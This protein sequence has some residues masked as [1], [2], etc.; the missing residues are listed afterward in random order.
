MEG[1]RWEENTC[2]TDTAQ[3]AHTLL[4]SQEELGLST[5]E[6]G[7]GSSVLSMVTKCVTTTKRKLHH[8]PHHPA[9]PKH[10]EYLN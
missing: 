5:V 6:Q 8:N 10:C 4:L 1:Q 9:L 2:C 7:V 3:L